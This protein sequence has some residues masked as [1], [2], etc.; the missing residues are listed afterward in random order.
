MVDQIYTIFTPLEVA[1]FISIFAN[2]SFMI[3]WID[4]KIEERKLN[5]RWR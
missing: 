4:N 1:F 3:C 5:K 2:L